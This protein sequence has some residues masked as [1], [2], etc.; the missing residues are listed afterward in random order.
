MIRRLKYLAAGAGAA[1]AVL[2]FAT[3]VSL[4]PVKSSLHAL[5]SNAQTLQITDRKGVPLTISYQNRWNVYDN[6]HLHEIPPLLRQA[7]VVSEDKRF[8]LHSGVDWRARGSAAL[9]NWKSGRVLRGASTI[10]EQVVRMVNPRPRNLWSKWLEGWE[11]SLLER[12]YSKAEILEFY[13]NQVPYAS[14]RRGVAQAARYYFDRDLTTLTARE[15]LALAVLARAPSSYDLYKDKSKIDAAIGR[16]AQAMFERGIF[17][18]EETAQMAAQGFELAQPAAPVNAEHFATYVRAQGQGAGKAIQTT[19]DATLQTSVQRILDDRVRTLSPKNL[20]NAAALVADHTTGE[21]LA[22]VVAGANDADTPGGRIDAVTVPRQPGSAQKPLLYALALDKGWTP[23]T[24]IEDS[25]LAEAIGTGLHNF[26]NYSNTYYGRVTLREALANSLNIPALRT[27]NYVGKEKY[28]SALHRL[29]FASLDRGVDI[30]DEGLALGNGEVTLLELVQAFSALANRGVFR[31][32]YAVSGHTSAVA[33]ERVYSPEAASLIGNILS[34]PWARRLE[35]GGGSVL[36]FPVQTAAKT[37]TSTDY[38]DAW[39]VGYNHK[40]VV[41]IWMGNLD[42]A[43]T[44]GVTGATG[45]ALAMRSI[46]S[47]MN[48]DVE[49]KPLWLSPRLAQKD[50]CVED[51]RDAARCY[52]RSEFFME[53][54]ENAPQE[55]AAQR[56]E[57]VKPTHGL[58]MA[59]DPRIPMDKQ[60]LPFTMQGL[61]P[62]QTVEWTLNGKTLGTSGEK[63]MWPLSRGTFRLSARVLEN[64]KPVHTSPEVEYI[65]R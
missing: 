19:L 55:T 1:C 54:A 46:F 45:P 11:A 16:L 20:H 25:P 9:Q 38:R 31:P 42:R 52:M 47:E 35:F 63:F 36:N 8:F 44:D 28:L 4:T 29:G 65:V 41:G 7:F 43:P 59:V 62:Q 3:Y 50:I 2:A 22:W 37:G 26:K 56:F 10:T 23:A 18:A 40:Y 39:T 49:S 30:Y 6:L 17:T 5:R 24:V 53:G 51:P 57:I 32:L 48:R 64:G 14:N 15:M 33:N 21:I 58:R 34:D 12:G 61:R 27:I 60:K 13:L